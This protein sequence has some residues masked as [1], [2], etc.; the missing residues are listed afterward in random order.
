MSTP[1]RKNVCRSVTLNLRV[2]ETGEKK[3]CK[4]DVI[5]RNGVAFLE[6]RHGEAALTGP[7]GS[8]SGEVPQEEGETLT[9]ELPAGT[10]LESIETDMPEGEGSIDFQDGNSAS[11]GGE[12]TGQD[13]D[14]GAGSGS[15]GAG[16]DGYGGSGDGDNPP[17]EVCVLNPS[18]S[19]VPYKSRV[20]IA[21]DQEENWVVIWAECDTGSEDS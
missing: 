10:E 6:A 9:A 11:G 4:F 3:V 14:G 17:T 19:V 13:Y 21:Q 5:F 20:L 18:A 2:I 1:T 12:S 7:P 16:S 8:V 15:G